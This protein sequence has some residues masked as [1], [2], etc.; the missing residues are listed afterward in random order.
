L[1]EHLIDKHMLDSGYDDP[2]ELLRIGKGRCASELISMAK[3]VSRDRIVLGRVFTDAK[4]TGNFDNVEKAKNKLL[5]S[6]LFLADWLSSH[7]LDE[8]HED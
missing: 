5:M 8:E 2:E 3:D 6:A 1:R 4:R 7:P